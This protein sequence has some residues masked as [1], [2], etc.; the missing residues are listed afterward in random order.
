MKILD[1]VWKVLK[2]I[3]LVFLNF[4]NNKIVFFIYM[5]FIGIGLFMGLII[6]TEIDHALGLDLETVFLA[7]IIPGII[8]SIVGTI[9]SNRDEK[10]EKQK[11]NRKAIED[12]VIDVL[13]KNYTIYQHI[14]LRGGSADSVEVLNYGNL[15]K[16]W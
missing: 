14:H 16:C 2:K 13:S 9:G 11:L 8:W 12:A 7:S 10:I 4:L 3:L 15:H 5:C 6:L 1:A